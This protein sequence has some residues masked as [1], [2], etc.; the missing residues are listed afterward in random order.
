VNADGVCAEHLA[1]DVAVDGRGHLHCAA[2]AAA[3]YVLLFLLTASLH[4]SLLHVSQQVLRLGAVVCG[5][6]EISS[7]FLR[8]TCEVTVNFLEAKVK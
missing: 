8:N 2:A 6:L 3:A 4:F 7:E 5:T 1:A